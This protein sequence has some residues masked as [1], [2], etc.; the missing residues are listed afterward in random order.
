MRECMHKGDASEGLK[1]EKGWIYQRVYKM[2]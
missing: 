2:T 1:G